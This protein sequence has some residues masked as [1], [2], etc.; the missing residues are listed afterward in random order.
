MDLDHLLDQSGPP[1]ARRTP[2]L[3]EELRGLVVASEDARR[4]RRRA[5]M[6]LVGGV[7]LGVLGLG[8]VATAAGVLPGWGLLTTGSGQT[9]EVDVAVQALSPGYGEPSAPAFSDAEQAATLAAAR[10]FLADLDYD[11]IDR[12]D[13]ISDWQ[14]AEERVRSEQ[15]DPSERQPALTGDDLEVTAVQHAVVERMRSALAAQGHDLRAVTVTTGNG[16]RL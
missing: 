7:A 11:A 10:A 12:E 14:S 8:T 15:E 6:T 5:R 9:C 1:V 13:A 3:H 16:C 2:E 4:P